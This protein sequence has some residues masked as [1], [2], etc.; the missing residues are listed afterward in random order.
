MNGVA[1]KE[2][3]GLLAHRGTWIGNSCPQERGLGRRVG[4]DPTPHQT[5]GVCA[6]VASGSSGSS[7]TARGKTFG[8]LRT[9][10][11]LLHR[12]AQRVQ[13]ATADTRVRIVEHSHQVVHNLLGDEM[14]QEET[15]AVAHLGVLVVKT[16][17]DRSQRI[18]PGA[19]QRTIR[20]TGVVLDSQPFDAGFV[21]DVH[22]CPTVVRG[23]NQLHRPRKGFHAACFS[24]RT[25][26][27]SGRECTPDSVARKRRTS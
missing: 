7:A 10:R 5:N 11:P 26:E 20:R 14:I 4:M 19:Q 18:E 8:L 23:D 12:S 13:S 25:G 1:G 17:A 22:V 24:V 3:T 2:P 27:L 6:N 15:A 21:V 16:F 9:T